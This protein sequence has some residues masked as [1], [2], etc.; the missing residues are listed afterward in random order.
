MSQP[1]TFGNLET[2]KESSEKRGDWWKEYSTSYKHPAGERYN[3][4]YNK[5]D[6]KFNEDQAIT[7]KNNTQYEMD[8]Q[9]QCDMELGD[10]P[11]PD[12]KFNEDKIIDELQKYIDSTYEGHYSKNKFQSMEFIVDCG[13]G[14]SFC[15]GNIIKYA[16]RYGKKDG[17][18]RKDLLKVMHYAIIALGVLDDEL[19]GENDNEDM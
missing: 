13:H 14:D 9:R 17:K 15:L 6:Y 7:F 19:N 8:L 3:E 18:N 2:M 1:G 10:V 4:T 12:Y 16:Q 11:Q 5:I